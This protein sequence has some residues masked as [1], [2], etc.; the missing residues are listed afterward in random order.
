M[1]TYAVYPGWDIPEPYRS[2]IIL[3]I[4]IFIGITVMWFSKLEKK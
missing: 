3:G 4:G 2:W 1:P